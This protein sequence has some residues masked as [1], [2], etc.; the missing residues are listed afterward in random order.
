MAV[1]LERVVDAV[2]RAIWRVR[3]IPGERVTW[4]RCGDGTIRLEIALHDGE[5]D[6]PE[7]SPPRPRAKTLG[8]TT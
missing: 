5:V 7:D 6:V 1:P 3:N 8:R 2:K 4:R